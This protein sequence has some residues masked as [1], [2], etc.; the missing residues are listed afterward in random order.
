MV[1]DEFGNVARSISQITE[2]LKSQIKL[3]A[4]QRDQFSRLD[5]SFAHLM[6]IIS[7]KLDLDY[8]ET[9]I[10]E[11]IVSKKPLLN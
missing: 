5:M 4:K 1:V 2:D 6:G 10:R 7:T 11:T 3:I 8:V 9:L